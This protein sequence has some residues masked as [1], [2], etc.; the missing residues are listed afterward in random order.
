MKEDNR[1]RLARMV[2]RWDRHRGAS[3]HE[4]SDGAFHAELARLTT[5]VLRPAL[6]DVGAELC[7]AG[8]SFRIEESAPDGSPRLDFYVV[9]QGRTGSKD[10]IQFVVRRNATRGLELIVELVLKS[11]PFELRRFRALS[12]V[13]ADIVEHMLVDAIEQLLAS[14]SS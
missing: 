10:L 8:H 14:P 6:Q 7:R 4:G 2:A 11:S 13:R 9:V 12:E 5:S 1:A 3:G